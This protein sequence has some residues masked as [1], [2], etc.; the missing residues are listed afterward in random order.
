[1]GWVIFFL[2]LICDDIDCLSSKYSSPTHLESRRDML[3]EVLS[4]CIG[5]DVEYDDA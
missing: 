4:H 1:M 5:D 3:S 2:F